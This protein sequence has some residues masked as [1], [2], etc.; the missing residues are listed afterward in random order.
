MSKLEGLLQTLH[1]TSHRAI[2]PHRQVRGDTRS[3]EEGAA[4]VALAGGQCSASCYHSR[5]NQSL[6]WRASPSTQDQLGSIN[7]FGVDQLMAIV[8]RCCDSV[9]TDSPTH[10]S[11][12]APL[13][14]NADVYTHVLGLCPF[15]RKRGSQKSIYQTANSDSHE[16]HKT[17]VYSETA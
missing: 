14:C 12:C 11:A 3:Q 2:P 8:F 9:C 5:Q 15:M 13:W 1:D 16:V 7:G 10:T 6:N 4:D 17:V